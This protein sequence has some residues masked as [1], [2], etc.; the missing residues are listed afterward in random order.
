MEDVTVQPRFEH[1][2]KTIQALCRIAEEK[3]SFSKDLR[4]V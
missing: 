2:E 3:L 1:Q 4:E